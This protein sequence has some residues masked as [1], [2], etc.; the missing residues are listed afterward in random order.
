MLAEVSEDF[1]DDLLVMARSECAM[2]MLLRY[3][4]TSP[5]KMRSWKMS[6]IIVWKVAGELVKPKYITKGSKSPWL[7]WNAVKS[8]LHFSHF[9]FTE[10][11]CEKFKTFS[12]L[13]DFISKISLWD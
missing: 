13:F 7:V 12:V 6:F 1:L 8:F 2:R 5:D 10:K 3:T 11:V 9:F 4:M